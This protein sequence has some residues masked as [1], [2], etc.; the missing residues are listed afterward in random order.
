[1]KII[2]SVAMLLLAGV[3]GVETAR[4]QP[5]AAARSVWDGV[6]TLE[7]ARRGAAQVDRCRPCHGDLLEGALAPSLVGEGFRDRWEGR[8]L[9]EL[10]E[11]IQVNLAAM[12]ARRQPHES[13]PRDADARS[14]Q[15]SADILA[16]LL[17]Q[18]VFPDGK[19]EVPADAD[20]LREIRFTAAKH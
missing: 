7:Q 17:V 1:M 5:A 20:R 6:Y 8:T 18:S 15:A 2:L 9:A 12:D 13:A 14:R 16:F 19:A 3:H 4:R 11:L 10:F